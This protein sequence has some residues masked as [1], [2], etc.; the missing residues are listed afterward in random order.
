MWAVL[1]NNQNMIL[2]VPLLPAQGQLR[3]IW[4]CSVSKITFCCLKPQRFHDH[5]IL[6]HNLAYP[7]RNSKELINACDMENRHTHGAM[8]KSSH[9]GQQL[10]SRS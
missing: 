4:M 1:F 7:N 3:W 6:Q 5:W 9:L 10:I 2:Y 8:L